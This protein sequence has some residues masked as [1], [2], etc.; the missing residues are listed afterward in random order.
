MT[1]YLREAYTQKE[2][3]KTEEIKEIQ[4]AEEKKEVGLISKYNALC[5]FLEKHSEY[6]AECDREREEKRI[7]EEYFKTKRKFNL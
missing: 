1:V 6:I 5:S 4:K 3:Q 7:R 2:I